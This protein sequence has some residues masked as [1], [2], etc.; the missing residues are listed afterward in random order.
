ML[1]TILLLMLSIKKASTSKCGVHE[2]RI[3]TQTLSN[4]QRNS[5]LAPIRI[6]FSQI[7][8]DLGLPALND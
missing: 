6:H 8:F 4:I 7:D 2:Y 3:N 5:T 1:L